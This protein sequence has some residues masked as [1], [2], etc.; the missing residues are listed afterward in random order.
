MTTDPARIAQ[1]AEELA[2]GLAD[3]GNALMRTVLALAPPELAGELGAR[4]ASGECPCLTVRWTA[5]R[6][7]VRAGLDGAA[8]APPTTLA[9]MDFETDRAGSLQ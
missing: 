7:E 8:D 3:V 5:D 4:L 2:R 6:V 1:H 9:A